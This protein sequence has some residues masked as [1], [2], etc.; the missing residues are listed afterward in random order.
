M[1][2]LRSSLGLFI[3]ILAA[4]TM[5]VV[6]AGFLWQNTAAKTVAADPGQEEM[7]INEEIVIDLGEDISGE[8]NVFMAISGTGYSGSVSASANFPGGS[9]VPFTVTWSVTVTYTAGYSGTITVS[10]SGE[11]YYGSTGWPWEQRSKTVTSSVSFTGSATKTTSASSSLGSSSLYGTS[12]SSGVRNVTGNSSGTLTIATY[13]ITWSYKNSSGGNASTTTTVSHGTTPSAP[14]VSPSSYSTSSTTYYNA[15]SNK[16][17]TTTYTASGWSP[18]ITAATGPTTYTRTYTNSSSTTYPTKY[19]SIALYA[20]TATASNGGTVTR[21]ISSLQYNASL[22]TDISSNPST[23]LSGW[24]F[25]GYFTS[26]NGTGTQYVGSNKQWLVSVV[27]GLGWTSTQL[28]SETAS[29]YALYASYKV[30]IT[31]NVNGGTG[32]SG[33]V[34]FYRKKTSANQTQITSLPTRFG[35]DFDGYFSATSGGIKYYN[36]DGT[37]AVI[38]NT[39]HYYKTTTAIS[40][41]APATTLYAQWTP[42]A[43]LNLTFDPL[44][45]EF[46]PSTFSTKTITYYNST[47]GTLPA[48]T[49]AAPTVSKSAFLLLGW[50]SKNGTGTNDWGTQITSATLYNETNL[51]LDSNVNGT[52]YAKWESIIKTLYLNLNFG[53]SPANLGTTYQ[54]MSGY[55]YASQNDNLSAFVTPETGLPAGTFARSGYK[56]IGWFM[57]TA[58]TGSEITPESS[59][60]LGNQD[61]TLYAKWQEKLT[62]TIGVTMG[63][64][65]YLGAV[66]S[67]QFTAL[68][69]PTN[70]ITYSFAS[71]GIDSLGQNYS[72][73][74]I[75][76]NGNTPQNAGNYIITAY[77]PET[78]DY[79]AQTTTGTFTVSPTTPS[80]LV[81]ISNYIYGGTAGPKLTKTSGWSQQ[82]FDGLT[83]E[84]NSRASGAY[85]GSSFNGGAGFSI[86]SVVY[87]YSG[88]ANNGTVI[89]NSTSA[90]LLAGNYTVYAVLPQTPNFNLYST[91]SAPTSFTVTRQDLGNTGQ[92]SVTTPQ[93]DA[94]VIIYGNTVGT[95]DINSIMDVAGTLYEWDEPTVIPDVLKSVGVVVRQSFRVKLTDANT[96]QYKYASVLVNPAQAVWVGYSGNFIP[97]NWGYAYFDKHNFSTYNG[98]YDMP[99]SSL[100]LNTAIT[101]ISGNPGTVVGGITV[102]TNRGAINATKWW[103]WTD[104]T[105]NDVGTVSIN[106]EYNP[107]KYY[108]N[109]WNYLPASGTI[110]I[111]VD[112][113]Y[114]F[115][116]PSTITGTYIDGMTLADL[117]VPS[118]KYTWGANSVEAIDYSTVN[119]YIFYDHDEFGDDFY[120]QTEGQVSVSVAKATLASFPP[121][122]AITNIVYGTLLSSVP[123]TSGYQWVT[124]TDAA[125]NVGINMHWASYTKDSNYNS[126]NGEISVSVIPANTGAF[127]PYGDEFSAP[128][129]STL[130]SIISAINA[131]G[132]YLVNSGDL[133]IVFNNALGTLVDI[134]VV[135]YTNN[136]TLNYNPSA[137]GTVGVRVVIADGI[138]VSPGALTATYGD[139]LASVL[140]GGASLPVTYTW[141]TSLVDDTPVLLSTLVGNAGTQTKFLK[142]SIYGYTDVTSQV[143]VAVAKKQSVWA[144]PNSGNP[145]GIESGAKL[146]TVS[147]D[148][149]YSWM[150]PNTDGP[151]GAIGTTQSYAATYYEGGDTSNYLAANGNITVE[152]TSYP[153]TAAFAEVGPYNTP[154]DLTNAVTLANLVSGGLA[155]WNTSLYEFVTPST[156]VNDLCGTMGSVRVGTFDVPAQYRETIYHNWKQGTV[157][158]TVTP[159]TGSWTSPGT[160]TAVYLDTLAE[161][162]ANGS[163][164]SS[165]YTWVTD[166]TGAAELSL[167]T[168]VG[169][170]GTQNFYLK[171]SVPNYTDF[172]Q[173]VGITVDKK[174]SEWPGYSEIYLPDVYTLDSITLNFENQL[175][176]WTWVWSGDDGVGDGTPALVGNPSV[177]YGAEG[178]YIAVVSYL[179]N[180]DGSNYYVNYGNITVYVVQL[181]EAT[182]TWPDGDN[183]SVTYTIAY[184]ATATLADVFT[185]GEIQNSQSDPGLWYW[186][187]PST[188]LISSFGNVGTHSVQIWYAPDGFGPFTTG[189]ELPVKITVSL[190][191]TKGS[192]TFVGQTTFNATYLDTLLD[193][194]SAYG[195][196]TYNYT[197][198]D[199]DTLQDV[200]G[201][202]LVELNFTGSTNRY[203]LKYRISS[204]YNY[205]A[206]EPTS[207]TIAN[208]TLNDTDP[209]VTAEISALDPMSVDYMTKVRDIPF[210]VGGV[211]A[212]EWAWHASIG[213]QQLV[214]DVGNRQFKAVLTL[215]NYDPVD[216]LLTV[217]VN[218]I[219][220]PTNN[221]TYDKNEEDEDRI[222]YSSTLT[223]ADLNDILGTNYAWAVIDTTPV[224][225]VVFDI[226]GEVD[227]KTFAGTYNPEGIGSGNFIASNVTIKF[228]VY[229][230]AGVWSAPSLIPDNQLTY[231][232]NAKVEDIENRLPQYYSFVYPEDYIGGSTLSLLLEV[233]Y[234]PDT[235]HY[236]ISNMVEFVVNKADVAWIPY[237]GQFVAYY[238]ALLKDIN[239]V[240][241]YY[242]DFWGYADALGPTVTY[243]QARLVTTVG[244]VGENWLYA[245]YNPDPANYNNSLA[246]Q[247][248][249]TVSKASYNELDASKDVPNGLEFTIDYGKQLSTLYVGAEFAVLPG[250]AAEYRFESNYTA[251]VTGVDSG[252]GGIGTYSYILYRNNPIDDVNPQEP[253]GSVYNS[254]W[255][256]VT[257]Y[258]VP[259]TAVFV[260]PSGNF[261]VPYG[262][263]LGDIRISPNAKR[264][265]WAY[266][267]DNGTVIQNGALQS[268]GPVTSGAVGPKTFVILYNPGGFDEYGVGSANYNSTQGTVMVEVVKANPAFV[269]L[270]TF[271]AQY[272]QKLEQVELPANYYWVNEDDVV[273]S[274]GT[275]R[276][277]VR[278]SPDPTSYNWVYGEVEIV[279]SKVDI[280]F[281]NP[282]WEFVTTY[283]YGKT[284]GDVGFILPYGYSWAF[285]ALDEFLGDVAYQ[286]DGLETVY[287]SNGNIMVVAKRFDNALIYNPNSEN[288]N[289]ILGPIYIMI[290]QQTAPFEAYIGSLQAGYGQILADIELMPTL[291][292]RYRW[293]DS[294]ASA[295]FVGTHQ[296]EVWYIPSSYNFLPSRGTVTVIVNQSEAS[297]PGSVPSY[298][299]VY[300]TLVKNIVLPLNFIWDWE[301]YASERGLT[302]EQVKEVLTVGNV[303]DNGTILNKIR[304]LYNPDPYNQ[305]DTVALIDITVTK[306]IVQWISPSK[307]LEAIYGQTLAMIESLPGAYRWIDGTQSVGSAGLRSFQ[308]RYNP[309]LGTALEGNYDD[310]L[311]I[312]PVYVNKAMGSAAVDINRW[313]SG[314]RQQNP[315]IETFT[316][317]NSEV[318]YRYVGIK[319]TDYDSNFIPTMAGD[320][321][322]YITIAENE[323]YNTLTLN[324][325]F[326]LL[327]APVRG[328]SAW[329]WIV[330]P[331]IILVIIALIVLGEYY[332]RKA[333][334]KQAGYVADK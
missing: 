293:V 22:T 225:N 78:I 324:Y 162:L 179:E 301:Y 146:S 294:G 220:A 132:Y 6:G 136:D 12:P 35:Y 309:Y 26:Y 93:S 56:F 176:A 90:P 65:E 19:Y 302:V 109:G 18:A 140:A 21:T 256:F 191:V 161:V 238:G 195:M 187:D 111:A 200:S 281:S 245:V 122:P 139:T 158:I 45:G 236:P 77:F 174:M 14:T 288:Y 273:G 183:S 4:V 88:T 185:N 237:V 81:S 2:V 60:P 124:P 116:L 98:V 265:W 270:G 317:R 299:R 137:A 216:V 319:G 297:V 296:V 134:D 316:H 23:T 262:S 157:S 64:Y 169:G 69:R 67:P 260:T 144:A 255:A 9:E 107:D 291:D 54:A 275:N 153:N 105:I 330:F 271:G 269:G 110:T 303:F 159:L 34:D 108:N 95:L 63:N 314:N 118:A 279:V 50:F 86:E 305:L 201:P 198:Y 148:T 138:W 251:G 261:S 259:A 202:S 36:S 163:A 166:I 115:E 8:D 332:R 178:I 180:N 235:N 218:Q 252:S 167:S 246:G 43:N 244:G 121:H 155:G 234:D 231:D 189:D 306:A 175:S 210:E 75:S 219:N 30:N 241:N 230:A 15:T 135:Y 24:N 204:N 126:I 240:G 298:T 311:Y 129:N 290:L 190:V 211:A 123:L 181:P 92:L 104:V 62:D 286:L 13:T 128:Y 112:Q 38:N 284:I 228:K 97:V 11:A 282:L 192:S 83:S 226:L 73:G 221:L 103:G 233:L 127:V 229:K 321:T 31:L 160:L 84:L 37:L 55:T 40:T 106:A 249:I 207:I 96:V 66:P 334:Q 203:S 91:S 82:R 227:Y 242:W 331:L 217:T 154:Y 232:P 164:L 193:V 133:T 263:T 250:G 253:A 239:L 130:S 52:I 131:Q 151:I 277:I 327:D 206:I 165:A 57:D 145:Y 177:L 7:N 278:Y 147:L 248:K 58:G 150:A 17:T 280:S 172:V 87:Y 20:N 80:V 46:N 194:L 320:Y 326:T 171:Y 213:S 27:S 215:P 28:N 59:H 101:I 99:L 3:G 243:E 287:D 68:L 119:A 267:E 257:V 33:S 315:E 266:I 182:P 25:D 152:I 117:S 274:V 168:L 85:V 1:K 313:V 5:L 197:W 283:E 102:S 29:T 74:N 224:G 188:R 71:S 318:T 214:G 89:T 295:G 42:K 39:S 268:V 10:V 212:T 170:A 304:A 285:G 333:R 300:G 205:S 276:K 79:K 196:S 72:S 16:T 328:G 149:G 44:G 41:D 47:I 312:I 100:N 289:D 173:Q 292:G 222:I 247:I 156:L 32:G 48:E 61:R 94:L 310:A 125:G 76:Q 141:V 322:V 308:A 51:V 53:A 184:S 272:G 307:L 186:V 120:Y 209:I 143:S 49:G 258:V 114:R 113:A 254:S 223:L 329:M 208:G 323:N 142:Y 264:Y 70:S 325:D 199:T